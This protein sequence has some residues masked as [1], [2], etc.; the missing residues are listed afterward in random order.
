MKVKKKKMKKK[1]FNLFTFC[2]TWL[3]NIS[4][5]S[6]IIPHYK[7]A[8]GYPPKWLFVETNDA[9]GIWLTVFRAFF[10]IS[11]VNWENKPSTISKNNHFGGY[12]LTYIWR[13]RIGESPD[14]S[15]IHVIKKLKK[16]TFFFFTFLF[17]TFIFFQKYFHVK[18][19]AL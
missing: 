3:R 8:S 6:P 12:L 17:F 7:Y 18:Y 16:L 10:M 14:M 2:V 5:D 9:F 4:V 19:N 11:D 15:L 1:N 13:G